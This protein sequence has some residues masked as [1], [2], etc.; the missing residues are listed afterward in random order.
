MGQGARQFLRHAAQAGRAGAG[1]GHDV[2]FD[3]DWQ[4]T[5]QLYEKMR[6]DVVS[7][8]VLPPSARELKARLERRAEDSGECHPAPAAK[9]CQG[10][11]ALGGIRLCPDQPRSRQVVSRSAAHSC[12]RTGSSGEAGARF[13]EGDATLARR[14]Q[15][16]SPISPDEGAR[17]RDEAL[18]RNF[19]GARGRLDAGCGQQRAAHRRRAS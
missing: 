3:I 16:I 4:G 17:Q 5:Q 7:V 8:F 12:R 19:L 15:K 13:V 1:C 11:S 14:T 9:R 6:A 2:L 18:D 10:N